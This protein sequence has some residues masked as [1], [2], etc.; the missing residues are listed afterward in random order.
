MKPF[1]FFYFFFLIVLTVSCMSDSRSTIINPVFGRADTQAFRISK[2]EMTEDTTIIYCSYTAE[3]AS[4]A[5]ISEKT[6]IE[7]IITHQKYEIMKCEGLPYPPEKKHF[8]KEEVIP[9]TLYFQ[10]IEDLSIFNLIEKPN[11]IAFNIYGIDL[12]A[13]PFTQEYNEYEVLSYIR[14]RDYYEQ[15]NNYEKA[16][17]YCEKSLQG[18]KFLFGEKS[19]GVGRSL[20]I[21][22]S[23]YFKAGKIKE[24][25]E[26]GLK[27]LSIDEACRSYLYNRILDED[28]IWD[29]NNLS[30]YYDEIGDYQNAI[31]MANKSLH[32]LE[33]NRVDN[34]E[35]A[36][37]LTNLA[38]FNNN[39]GNYNDALR[40]AK[41]S[42]IIKG[43]T[44]GK[45][46]E[47]YA[48]SLSNL[49]IAES[50]LGNY[51]EAIK[52][53][54][55]CLGIF[56]KEKGVDYI[57]NATILGNI[58]YNLA[59][60]NNYEEAIDYGLEACKV[61]NVQKV[62]NNDLVSFLSNIS[63]CYFNLACTLN[64]STDNPKVKHL[65]SESLSYSDSAKVVA[66][67]VGGN[68]GLPQILNNQAFILGLQKKLEDAIELQ[69]QACDMAVKTT[70]EYPLYLQNLSLYYLFSGKNEEAL[71][72][73]KKAI[74]IYDYRIKKNLT[75][76]SK[77]D[78]SN[79]WNSINDIY[80]NFIPK[81]A[82]Y[83]KDANAVSLLYDK[84]ALFAKGFLLNSN[85]SIKHLL[86]KEGN[87]KNIDDYNKL[88][89]LYAQLD[90]MNYLTDDSIIINSKIKL[91][92]EIEESII[93][94][95]L[96]YKKYVNN[97][98]CSWRDIRAKLHG[99]DIAI[100]FV[101]CPLGLFNDSV[102]YVA[103]ALKHD[104]RFPKMIPLFNEHDFTE[105]N[106]SMS[107]N[108]LYHLI[109]KPLE[110]EL[111]GV[112]NIYFSP[113]G[114]LYNL[115]L[116]YLTMDNGRCVSDCFRMFRLSSTRQLTEKV[117]NRNYH[118]A[119]LFGGISYDIASADDGPVS[120]DSGESLDRG[121]VDAFVKRGGFEE[122]N[123]TLS[124]IKQIG[125]VLKNNSIIPTLYYS[126]RGSEKN[127]K[128][129]SGADINI[130]HV[131]THGMFIPLER[132]AFNHN[133]NNFNF[134]QLTNFTDISGENTALTRSFIVMAG[135]NR[136]P[137]RIS[138]PHNEEDGILTA[139]EIS[140]LDFN[141]IDLVV[142]SACQ[143]AVGDVSEEGILG[144]Q[145]GFKKAGVNTI[146][147]SL[148]KVDDEA[149][150]ILM[151]EF[152]RNLMSG[153]TKRQSLYDAQQYLRK[154]ENGKYDD[155]KYWASFIMLDGLN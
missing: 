18:K 132:A 90:S 69:S 50:N 128:R 80:N 70:L 84:T 108:Q 155:P 93:H 130:L 67:R 49:A 107:Q 68:L 34:E 137:Q 142:L 32:L 113:T 139:L 126:E 78:I 64:D 42:V 44:V 91:I 147:M 74:D 144:L 133:E 71:N 27:G 17:Y 140:R 151:V 41:E 31:S 60:I 3:A 63:L 23:L 82:F 129:Q 10:P 58:S 94:N 33:K 59:M 45:D 79:Y 55:E 121:M 11:E 152:Y 141:S 118:Q 87:K 134:I 85:M 88:Q 103:L 109:W 127:F 5:N 26:Y 1:S 123:G 22:A 16:I 96:S 38:K 117:S 114:I 53:N 43:N 148:D 20:F 106:S 131:A 51:D 66:E 8:K 125:S 111:L 135:G 56:V 21:L 39:I 13:H 153:K 48:I 73:E 95:S 29:Y 77:Y 145:R 35:Y 4:W 99:S 83:S 150:K 46:S 104:F 119:S 6:Y 138:I 124:E 115:G 154:V 105:N 75:S 149:T 116:E 57:N 122:L 30:H 100:E 110:Q 37:V 120:D 98:N 47:S 146:L 36:A 9:V 76:L 25:I 72:I 15:I 40:Y 143:T 12:S 102:M 65:L 112:S 19:E 61:F 86:L 24:A 62:E 7:D 14:Q 136:L 2:V 54:K 28:L 81:C 101:R 92:Q 89:I 52:L 97:M